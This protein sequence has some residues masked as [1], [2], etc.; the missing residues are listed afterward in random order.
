MKLFEARETLITG[1]RRGVQW[2]EAAAMKCWKQ[3]KAR[4]AE[5]EGRR[6]GVRVGRPGVHN[7]RHGRR[8]TNKPDTESQLTKS[9]SN[10]AKP[11]GETPQVPCACL[12]PITYSSKLPA[13][14]SN[15][16]TSYTLHLLPQKGPKS[17]ELM[18]E[19]VGFVNLNEAESFVVSPTEVAD[20]VAESEP[21]FM[22]PQKFMFQNGCAFFSRM[23]ILVLVI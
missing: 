19:L 16:A 5:A 7:D 10:S 1:K 12:A 21:F 4:M 15:A 11:R 22:K 14:V 8:D 18:K 20:F 23:V 3:G 6:D 13:D 2:W 9:S 17:S